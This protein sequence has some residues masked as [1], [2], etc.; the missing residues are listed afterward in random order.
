MKR[1]KKLNLGLVLV[2]LLVAALAGCGPVE[3][4]PAPTEAS[5]A[6]PQ[7][8]T[9][10]PPTEAATEA[11]APPE[12]ATPVE[13]AVVTDSGLQYIEIE[14]GDGPAPQAGEVVAIDYVAKL[15][16]GG[17]FDNSYSR[18]EP[19]RFALGRGMVIPGLDEGIALMNLG[20]KATLIIPPELAYGSQ[21][22]GGVIPPDA[23][24][25][26]EVELVSI[27]PGSPENPTEVAD[28]DYVTTESGLKYYD[29][30]PGEGQPAEM[31]QVVSVQYTGWLADGTKFDSSIDRGRPLT[32]ALGQGQV[33]PGWEEGLTG[34]QIG[35]K[36][37]LVIPPE[38]GYGEQGSGG[39]IP[40]NATL[41]FD[42]ELLSIEAGSPA[43]PTEVDEADYETTD[44]GLQYYDLEVG[45]GAEPEFGQQV[46]VHYT[47]W[48]VDGTKFDSSL[49]RGEP[50][51]FAVGLGQVIA[52]WDEGVSTMKVGGKRQLVI[53]PELGYGE[54][55]AG[56][57]IPPGA[58]LIFEVE[59]IEIP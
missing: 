40:P 54:Q 35:G 38:L 7:E 59:L 11:V 47:G 58:T 24:I 15:E 37:Q 1:T 51:T 31:G 44:S 26:F 2:L 33:I 34:M 56:G 57:V 43:S 46:T 52:G 32:L 17:E 9:V 19:I 45:T 50:F 30:E 3:S 28:E 4:T 18:G 27:E 42:V 22:A 8:P 12:A 49:D 20:G 48:L 36:R 39:V 41:I 21:G 10:E 13:G 23:T 6:V 53:P 16:E 25:I 5:T 29:I 14:A 55:G